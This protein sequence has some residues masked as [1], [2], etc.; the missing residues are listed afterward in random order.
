LR[1]TTFWVQKELWLLPG[2]EMFDVTVLSWMPKLY[3]EVYPP[4]ALPTK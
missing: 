3:G 1:V 2:I 4:P